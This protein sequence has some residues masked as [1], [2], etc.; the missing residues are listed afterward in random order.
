M[1]TVTV[2][3][4]VRP[5]REA[6]FLKI[7]SDVADIVETEEP[8]CVAYMVWET[9]TP[10]EYFLVE[11]YRSDAGREEHNKRHAAVA[12][13]FFACL[14]GPPETETLGRQVLGTPK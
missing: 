14:D 10:H 9:G 3:M 11:S 6:D 12:Q 13:E 4:K 8:D 7:F 5:E 1:S 2:R